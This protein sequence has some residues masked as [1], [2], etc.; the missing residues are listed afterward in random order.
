MFPEYK[1]LIDSLKG[2]EVAFDRLYDKHCALNAEIEKM[3]AK[4]GFDE[5][6]IDKLKKEKLLLKDEILAYLKSVEAK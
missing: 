3:T 5:D 2:K 1:E 6:I 4:D